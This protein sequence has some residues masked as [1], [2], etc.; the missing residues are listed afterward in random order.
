MLR[1]S[2]LMLSSPSAKQPAAGSAVAGRR[3]N[4]EIGSDAVRKGAPR[5]R[6]DKGQATARFVR[7]G[8]DSVEEL[9]GAAAHSEGRTGP[10]EEHDGGRRRRSG[11]TAVGPRG[12][13]KAHGRRGR[14]PV[15]ARAGGGTRGAVLEV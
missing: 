4:R 15:R 7:R 3:G 12:R 8:P 9:A 13:P 6:P 2:S 11:E 10:A 5:G 14:R 1:L